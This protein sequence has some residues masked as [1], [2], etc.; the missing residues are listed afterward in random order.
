MRWI[1][2][3]GL[4]PDDEWLATSARYTDELRGM[5][6]D[7]RR[8]FFDRPSVAAHWAALRDDL[9][10]LSD[11]KCWYSEA[12][13]AAGYGEVEHFRPKRGTRGSSRSR[14][15]G[16]WWLAFDSRNYRLSA[17]IPNRT[18]NNEFEIR[19]NRAAN[20]GDVLEDE[21]PVLLDPTSADNTS[22]V[23]FAEGGAMVAAPHATRDDAE[24]VEY[25]R[26][27]CGLDRG[28]IPRERELV[29]NACR[30]RLRL[31]ALY[32]R[33]AATSPS[34]RA[35]ADSE[36]TRLKGMVAPDQ[37]FSRVAFACLA[38]TGGLGLLGA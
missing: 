6:P 34:Q 18:K 28:R 33:Q 10:T 7:D 32:R 5:C 1:D 19:G 29:W 26:R 37:P 2:S 23:W 35:R 16:Y 17:S 3:N 22:L 36:A 25:T 31:W 14:H 12:K 20:E 30:D 13:I 9:M 11:G 4:R 27:R 38:Q 24:R 21:L 8:A 15:D